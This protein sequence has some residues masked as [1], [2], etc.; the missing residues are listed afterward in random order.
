MG[1]YISVNVLRQLGLGDIPPRRRMLVLLEWPEHGGVHAR[2]V[3]TLEGQDLLEVV[4]DV[5]WQ[6][7]RDMHRRGLLKW[8]GAKGVVRVPQPPSPVHPPSPT[9]EG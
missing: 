1:N 7:A 4:W 2:D 5:R 3:S 9:D 8:N 6:S